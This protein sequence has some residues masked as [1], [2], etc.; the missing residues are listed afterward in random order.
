[1]VSER[2]KEILKLIIEEYIKTAKPVSSKSL[3]DTLNCSSATIRSEMNYLEEIGLLEKTHISSGRVPSEIGY[4]YYVNNIM[5]PKE[6]NGDDILKLQTIFRNNSLVLSDAILKSLEIVSELTNCALVTLEGSSRENRV[7]KVEV[8]PVNENNVVAIIVTD[9]GHVENRNVYIEEKISP[10]EIKQTVDLINKYVVGTPLDEVHAKLEFEVKPV[11]GDNVNYQR[12]LFDAF[13]NFVNDV[14]NDSSFKMT[15]TSNI[16]KQPEF[17]DTNKIR[18]ILG[19]FEDKEFI[20]KIKA[21]NNE[22]S[23]YIGSETEFDDNV[24]IIKTKYSIGGEE[25]TIALIGPTR[26]EY[27]RVTTLLNYI[28]ENLE[29]LDSNIQ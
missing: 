26:M 4:R 22:V 8:I 1:M 14:A 11:I 24:S 18:E 28:K 13:C 29:N 25:G 10:I 12:K 6:L 5:V 17:D 23:V 9:K 7:S 2:Q 20:K 3:M 19:K 16:L 21:D 27:N 15:G